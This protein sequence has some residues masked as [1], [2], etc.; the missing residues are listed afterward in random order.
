MIA[1]R[2]ILALMLCLCGSLHG[3]TKRRVRAADLP[4]WPTTEVEFD[5]SL[6]E[7][8]RQANER[9]RDGENDHLVAYILQSSQFTSEPK[10]EPAISALEFV[11]S[12]P[13]GQ[14]AGYLAGRLQTPPVRLPGDV[15]RRMDAFLRTKPRDDADERIP[16]FHGL[17]AGRGKP[18]LIAAY[19]RTMRFLYQKESGQQLNRPPV[20]LYQERGYASDTQV[21]ANFAVWTA[22]SVLHLIE[23]RLAANRILIVGPGLD[24]AP[25]T[26]FLDLFPPQSYQPFAIADAL[27]ALG[28]SAPERMLVHS[29]DINPVVVR[30]LQ[31]FPGRNKKTISLVSGLRR[32]QLSGDFQDYFRNLGRKIGEETALDLPAPLASHLG[33]S[34]VVR[35]DVAHNIT[36]EQFN[37]V[38][39]RYDTSPAYDLVVATNILVYFNEQELRLALANISSML[40]PGGYLLHNELRPEIETIA[41]ELGLVAVQAR[42]IQISAGAGKPLLDSFVI[43]RRAGP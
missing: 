43:H 8:E 11:R 34:I 36:A 26:G 21:E 22:L 31:G 16:Y 18:Y 24:L 13:S 33:K 42:T 5:R 12:M 3:Q 6:A 38:T 10:I 14:R 32:V 23:P 35:P 25:R 9:L 4:S 15:L 17:V 39:E 20:D 2:P 40:R 37:I 28:M 1:G 19:M 29:L 27:L 7:I 30:F 41:R